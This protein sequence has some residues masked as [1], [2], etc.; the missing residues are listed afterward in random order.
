MKALFITAA[1]ALISSPVLHAQ[2]V[3]PAFEKPTQQ[4]PF[5]GEET[6]LPLEQDI[7][8]PY[9]YAPK[10]VR[11]QLEYIDLAHHTLTRL[12][13]E[14]QAP[15][16]NAKELC[17]KI[18]K[19]VESGDAKILE[20]QVAIARSGEMARVESIEE[21]IYPTE[22]DPPVTPSEDNKEKANPVDL[23]GYMP[24]AFE[25]RNVGSTLEIEPTIGE[26]D[27][28]VNIRLE[29]EIVWHSGNILW[30]EYKDGNGNVY[31]VEMPNF[32]TIRTTTALTCIGGQYNMIGVLSPKDDNGKVN[33]ER[34]VI[35][36]LKCDIQAAVR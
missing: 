33:F 20:T 26:N 27:T 9:A 1:L 2:D 34:K 3:P 6:E 22:Y 5:T 7:F 28:M 8:D 10:S 25:T 21:Y 11:V 14:D 12:L 4:D 18:Q 15:T 32:Y 31:K 23:A 16:T 13:M 35:L 17:M 19:L 29:P 24:W 36:F 30:Q